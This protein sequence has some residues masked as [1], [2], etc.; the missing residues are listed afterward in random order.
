MFEKYA[1]FWKRAAAHVI[2]QIILGIVHS[3][4]I[5]PLWMALFFR[6]LPL[7][8]FSEGGDYVMVGNEVLNDFPLYTVFLFSFMFGAAVI[9]IDWLY[10]AL[11]ES[12][13]KQATIGKMVLGIKVTDMAGNRI[14]FGKAS[15][16]YFGKILSGLIL[17][18][19]YFMAGFTEKKQALH[20]ILANCLVVNTLYDYRL[21]EYRKSLE[22]HYHEETQY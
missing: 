20:D 13:S 2:D 15:G 3:I 6:Y 8:E 17:L 1:G 22:D 4:I 9:I 12:S 11:M 18:I 19:G 14:G 10:Y 21:S 7:D 5:L 16:R